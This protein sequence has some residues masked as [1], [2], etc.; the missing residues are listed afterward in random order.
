MKNNS[1]FFPGERHLVQQEIGDGEIS[2]EVTRRFGS[3]SSHEKTRQRYLVVAAD[4]P[5]KFDKVVQPLQVMFRLSRQKYGK[6]SVDIL[7]SIKRR[8]IRSLKE[9]PLI[10]QTRQGVAM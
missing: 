2:F 8:T 9:L 1:D 4:F 5:G 3:A 7:R 6:L 10:G